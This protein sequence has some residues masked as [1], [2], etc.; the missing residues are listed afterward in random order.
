MNILSRLG[1]Y[2]LLMALTMQTA[3]LGNSPKASFFLLE[4]QIGPQTESP[5]TA[6]WALAVAP[7]KIPPYLQRSQLVTAL[8]QNGYRLDEMNRWAESLDDNITR[9]MLQDLTGLLAADVVPAASRRGKQALYQLSVTV[10]EFHIDPQGRANL[11]A[12]WQIIR[13]GEAV[14]SRQTSYRQPAETDD[15]AM[16]VQALNRC[17]AQLERDIARVLQGLH[18]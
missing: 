12:Q 3:C 14:L 11:S 10:L 5:V 4:P 8:G 9:V 16:Q 2:S 15:V 7:V 1:R 17:L 18:K 13:G 6:D